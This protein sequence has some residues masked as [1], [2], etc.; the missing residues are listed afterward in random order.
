MMVCS[1]VRR[2]TSWRSFGTRS[3]RDRSFAAVAI[4]VRASQRGRPAR[5]SWWRSRQRRHEL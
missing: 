5:G 4:A 2:G 1:R 3:G